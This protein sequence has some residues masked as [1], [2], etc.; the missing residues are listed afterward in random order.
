M[1]TTN[2]LPPIS[3][4]SMGL[5]ELSEA[6]PLIHPNVNQLEPERPSRVLPD[7]RAVW[8]TQ[9]DCLVRR[10]ARPLATWNTAIQ[11]GIQLGPWPIIFLAQN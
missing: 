3:S 2:P 6:G 9:A 4:L 5:A 11:V 10:G 1:E 7:C 8:N